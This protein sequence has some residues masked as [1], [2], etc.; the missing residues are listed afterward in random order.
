[1]AKPANQASGG[2]TA[3][4]TTASVGVVGFLVIIVLRTMLR[5]PRRPEFYGPRSQGRGRP[6]AI[7]MPEAPARHRAF[8]HQRFMSG[9]DLVHDGVNAVDRDSECHGATGNDPV[10]ER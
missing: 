3:N 5:T 2:T 9:A 7:G 4:G 10:S 6:K 8:R 1:M